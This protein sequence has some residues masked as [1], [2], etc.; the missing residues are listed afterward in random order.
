ME[1]QRLHKEGGE[2]GSGGAP[3]PGTDRRPSAP[4]GRPALR[5]SVCRSISQM[6]PQSLSC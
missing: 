1:E 2:S 3:S 4:P 6:P 5:C